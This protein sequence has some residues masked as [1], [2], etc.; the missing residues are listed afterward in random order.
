M[1][2]DISRKS[3]LIIKNPPDQFTNKSHVCLSNLSNAKPTKLL[4]FSH[5]V[6][7]NKIKAPSI[8]TTIPNEISGQPINPVANSLGEPQS[9]HGINRD[10][11]HHRFSKA[12]SPSSV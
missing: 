3:T 5:S 11:C 1:L 12:N 7:I 10:G 2:N 8:G 6:P 9:L 4:G